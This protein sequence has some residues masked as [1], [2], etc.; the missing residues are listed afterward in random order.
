MAAWAIVAAATGLVAAPVGMLP[1]AKPTLNNL[2]PVG[3]IGLDVLL[4]AQGYEVVPLVNG[5]RSGWVYV[6][7]QVE[8]RP[9]LLMV[10]S[11]GSA[12]GLDPEWVHSIIPHVVGVRPAADGRQPAFTITSSLTQFHP[13]L[14]VGDLVVPKLPFSYLPPNGPMRLPN[15][16]VAECVGLLG[17]PFLRYYSALIDYSTNRLYLLDPAKQEPALRGNWEGVEVDMNG[18]RTPI[19][20]DDRPRLVITSASGVYT[21][22]G[23][24]W[25]FA[26][27]FNRSATPKQMDWVLDTGAVVP[28]LYKLDGDALTVTG[29]LFQN[30]PDPKRRP[31]KLSGGR[32]DP[33]SAVT[34]RRVKPKP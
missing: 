10:D 9:T 16:R 26:V 33:N 25:E 7:A 8:G 31:T 18:G 1:A 4:R 6:K 34:F 19:G 30:G 28:L 29:Y 24:K 14:R 27:R 15:D 11:G 5:R 17:A 3:T 13:K 2:P 20:P 21:S 12:N 22:P 23:H 32:G